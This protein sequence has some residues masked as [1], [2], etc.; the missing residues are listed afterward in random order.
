MLAIQWQHE[1][2]IV[3][4]DQQQH[5][6]TD[7]IV[8]SGN[9]AANT[10]QRT[11][12]QDCIHKQNHPVLMEAKLLMM[13]QWFELTEQVRTHIPRKNEKMRKLWSPRKWCCQTLGKT[14]S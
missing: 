6:D 11:T 2:L 9:D 7:N 3:D 5:C 14:F 12:S 1:G 10:A 13:V 4:D 8:N